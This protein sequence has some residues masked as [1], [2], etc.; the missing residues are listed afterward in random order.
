METFNNQ[1]NISSFF[2]GSV[3]NVWCP[4][5][6]YDERNL[7]QRHTK[8]TIGVA[9]H[10]V[11]EMCPIFNFWPINLNDFYYLKCFNFPMTSHTRTYT[12]CLSDQMLHLSLLTFLLS[13]TKTNIKW[14][15]SLSNNQPLFSTTH[16][17]FQRIPL[18]NIFTRAKT[19]KKGLA[20]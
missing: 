15:C 13:K 18:L 11:R 1:Q 4:T 3:R 20:I 14:F 6:R 5:L 10:R 9:Y 16:L 19:N 7:N 8:A 2:S 17:G 12:N